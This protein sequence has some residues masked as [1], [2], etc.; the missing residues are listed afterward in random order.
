MRDLIHLKNQGHVIGLCGNY[1][2]GLKRWPDALRY[3]SFWGPQ[4][5]DN[6]AVY[7]GA[8]KM[9]IQRTQPQYTDFVMV[10]N[11]RQDAI[12]GGMVNGHRVAGT[13]QDDGWARLAGWRFV[14]EVDFAAGKR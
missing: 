4:H 7:L 14:R 1:Y 3:I 9:D 2:V 13:S 10:G 11:R 6:K 8:I 12:M 5:H